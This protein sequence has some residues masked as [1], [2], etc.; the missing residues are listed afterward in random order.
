M[1]SIQLKREMD[2]F[3]IKN[4]IRRTRK[5]KGLTQEE[6]A[7]LLNMSLTAYRD[8]EKGA[9]NM[10]NSNISR[11][12]EITDSSVEEIVLGYRPLSD[13]KILKEFEDYKAEYDN[14]EEALKTRIKDLEKIVASLE[15]IVVVK[16]E[17]INMLKKNID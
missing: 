10:L 2:N 16:N 7:H 11:I 3:S 5:E 6:M 9:T 8:L 4:N 14:R 1:F 15:E 17:I 13:D 12:A